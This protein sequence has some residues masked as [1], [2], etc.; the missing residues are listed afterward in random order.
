MSGYPSLAAA[1]LKIQ[2]D[3]YRMSR[4]T[5]L[6]SDGGGRV[7]QEGSGMKVNA[8]SPEVRD[9]LWYPGPGQ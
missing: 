1:G 8:G 3:Q 6:A 4:V 9:W 5:F 7:R 2:Q